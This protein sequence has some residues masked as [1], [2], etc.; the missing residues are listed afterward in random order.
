[1]ILYTFLVIAFAVKLSSGSFNEYDLA[2]QIG[3]DIGDEN[4]MSVFMRFQNQTL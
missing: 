2:Q 4:E 3:Y 1:M